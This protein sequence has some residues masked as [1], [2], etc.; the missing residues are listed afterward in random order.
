MEFKLITP[1]RL[2]YSGEAE[3]VGGR[4]EDGSFSVLPRHIPA[5]MELEPALLKV[6]SG[7]GTER[8][9]VHGGFLF[10]E[11]DETVKVLTREASDLGDIDVGKLEERIQELEE[12]L[13]SLNREGQPGH[14]DETVAELDRAELTAKL[15]KDE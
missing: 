2:V 6:E 1:D 9:V 5:V 15:V 7:G 13:S 11:R 10:K 3:L 8:F 4:T 12:E 14:Y